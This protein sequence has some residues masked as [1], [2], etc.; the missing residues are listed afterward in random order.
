MPKHS[1]I[2][3]VALRAAEPPPQGATT[4]WDGALKHFGV[5]ISQGGTKSFIVL[6]GSGR[7]QAIGRYPVIT[8]AQARDKARK[9]LAERTLGK[10]QPQSISWDEA[11]KQYLAVC[12]R[13]NRPSTYEEYSRA[14]TVYFP[15]KN[16]RLAEITKADINRQLD[17]LH[18]SPSQQRHAL[19]YLKIFFRW[20]RM[21]GYLDHDPTETLKA[22]KAPSRA[23]VLSD[24]EI[25][26]IWRAC[27]QRSPLVPRKSS[28]REEEAKDP[29]GESP[30]GRALPA[31][32][33]TIVRLLI[34]TGQ[35]RNEIASIQFS[36]LNEK[37]KTLTIP[38]S[39]AK[40]GIEITLPISPLTWSVLT[41]PNLKRLA[42]SGQAAELALLRVE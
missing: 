17:K 3:E 28:E 19:V 41:S 31:S 35:R 14:L 1:V 36:W 20:S 22:E 34:L 21:R 29:A 16:R 37:D 27:E 5:R 24:E 40:N 15:F 2:T 18:T 4:L 25:G 32:F 30:E 8:I 39:I 10:H 6:L 42:V 23:R 33:A 26:R 11:L 9:L 12:E 13:K 7:R 38:A